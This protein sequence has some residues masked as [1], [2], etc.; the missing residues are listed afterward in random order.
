MRFFD[1]R[2]E[3]WKAIVDAFV[4]KAEEQ[5]IEEAEGNNIE[6]PADTVIEAGEVE[7]E[8]YVDELEKAKHWDG[9]TEKDVDRLLSLDL[10]KISMIP[11]IKGWLNHIVQIIT[12]IKS[13]TATLSDINAYIK[14]CN[15]YLNSINNFLK[16]K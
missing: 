9:H 7:T 6:V 15:S 3:M 2:S 1:G 11:I 13:D 14:A 8:E 5:T 10:N 12:D 4:K 16:Q